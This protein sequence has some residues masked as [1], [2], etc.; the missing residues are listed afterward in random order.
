MT[1]DDFIA[2]VPKIQKSPLPGE[3]LHYEMAAI[4]R[5]NI[6]KDKAKLRNDVKVAATMML[7]YNFENETHF[8]LIKRK[9]SNTTH[10]GQ[11]A[12]PGGKF[13]ASDQDTLTT[14]MRETEEEIGVQRAI[15]QPIR[16]LTDIYIPPSNYKV[17]P[18]LGFTENKQIFFKP[19]QSEVAAI[20][21]LKLKDLLSAKV[22]PC[23]VETRYFK[24]SVPA[25]RIDEVVIWGATAMVLNEVRALF[26][27][28][29]F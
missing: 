28:H 19:Q 8:S 14:A 3:Q 10:S 18:Y 1:W 7:L 11:I 13:E 2:L 29:L 5:L 20:L 22:E 27:M 12:F 23:E 16:S 4:E 24:K 9:T 6:L 15:I 26:K 25:F 21:S 17:F